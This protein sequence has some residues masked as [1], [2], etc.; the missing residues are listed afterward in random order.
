MRDFRRATTSAVRALAIVAAALSA[1]AN[2]QA[3]LVNDGV[4]DPTFSADGAQIV[5]G[6]PGTDGALAVAVAPNFYWMAG[7][8]NN[9][10]GPF[11]AQA[12][13]LR[14]TGVPVVFGTD[15]HL[16]TN[17]RGRGYPS[18]YVDSQGRL[19][20]VLPDTPSA[21]ARFLPSGALDTS[22]SGDGLWFPPSGERVRDVAPGQNGTVWVS[23]QHADFVNAELLQLLANGTPS[24]FQP[25]GGVD[26][27]VTRLGFT[28]TGYGRL[29]VAA[30][31]SV[32]WSVQGPNNGLR[33]YFVRLTPSGVKD[34]T[35][36]GDG[37][38]EL[39][40]GCGIADLG[41]GYASFAVLPGNTAVARVNNPGGAGVYAVAALP[42][43]TPGPIRCDAETGPLATTYEIAARDSARF[44]GAG[45]ICTP[46]TCSAA[47]RRFLV[48]PNG[49]IVD[50]PAFDVNA[51]LASF[52]TLDG[53]T[54]SS[55]ALDL[56]VDQGKPVL[57]GSVRRTGTDSGMLVLRYGGNNFVF[58]NGFE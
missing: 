49:A 57:V 38:A 39:P 56:L 7:V 30:D 1:S 8:S 21:V 29:H 51:T 5:A 10:S 34:T 50:D 35:Y 15:G 2:A 14:D 24:S 40:A 27:G 18:S 26:E 54:P 4:P 19:V 23:Q 6:P 45:E 13:L 33:H 20:V 25:L 55:F 47:L 11:M 42:D 43:G 3:P 36:S 41:T 16:V 44:F 53:T 31:F 12:Q 46:Q 28:A 32:W 22:F 17:L 37:V 58:D 9:G 52:P 48:Q